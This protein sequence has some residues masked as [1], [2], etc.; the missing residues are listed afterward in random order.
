MIDVDML[1]TTYQDIIKTFLLNKIL[2]HVSILWIIENN[3]ELQ[4]YMDK[5]NSEWMAGGPWYNT[6]IC[7]EL[8]GKLFEG[9]IRNARTDRCYIMCSIDAHEK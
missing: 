8:H 4:Y 6:S 7:K 9:F 5:Q 3:E 2:H 1:N